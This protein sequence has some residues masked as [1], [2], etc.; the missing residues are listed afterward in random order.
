M[1]N[2]RKSEGPKRSV[3][4][5]TVSVIADEECSTPGGRKYVFEGAME[6]RVDEL[7]K[8]LNAEEIR[9]RRKESSSLASELSELD[10][11]VTAACDDQR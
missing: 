11:L 3:R 8:A 4:F 10:S 6:R 7:I 5:A 2:R 9:G 1:S